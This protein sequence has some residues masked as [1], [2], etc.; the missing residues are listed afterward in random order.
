VT[1]VVRRTD[2]PLAITLRCGACSATLCVVVGSW[3]NGPI[4]RVV[5]LGGV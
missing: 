3:G 1:L 4:V 5:F 2:A